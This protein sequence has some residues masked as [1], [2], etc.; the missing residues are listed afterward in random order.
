M[1]SALS[2]QIVSMWQPTQTVCAV[3]VGVT[4]ICVLYRASTPH[5]VEVNLMG[6]FAANEQI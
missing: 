3:R 2:I 4:P 1:N 6:P 5:C